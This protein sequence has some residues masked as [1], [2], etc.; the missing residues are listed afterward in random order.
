MAGSV[1]HLSKSL[2]GP[3][4]PL[5]ENTLPDC[6]NPAP[7]VSSNGE[8]RLQHVDVE[9][10]V[11]GLWSTSLVPLARHPCTQATGGCGMHH[12]CVRLCL[13]R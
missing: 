13:H 12:P 10:T 1:I 2:S 9:W 8:A 5:T 7:F 4:E 3:W 11:L 6:N